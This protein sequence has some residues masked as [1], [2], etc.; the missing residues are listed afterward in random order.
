MTAFNNH[1]ISIETQKDKK[2]IEFLLDNLFGVN[3]H[4]RTVYK[5]RNCSP[6]KNLCLVLKSFEKNSKFKRILASIRFWPIKFANIKGLILGPLAVR[7]EL[8]GLGFGQDLVKKS[9]NIAK[10]E[11]WK[12]CFVSGEYNYFKK[13]TVSIWL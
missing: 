9:I 10:K 13:C 12:L 11:N 4:E 1:I 8:Q 2:S 7:K 6:V 5:F 3:R